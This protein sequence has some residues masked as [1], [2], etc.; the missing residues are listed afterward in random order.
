MLTRYSC[1]HLISDSLPVRA[2]EGPLRGH[3]LKPYYFRH[4]AIKLG[5]SERALKGRPRQRI[6]ILIMVAIYYFTASFSGLL[7]KPCGPPGAG[8]RAAKIVFPW[9]YCKLVYSRLN[10]N[11]VQ[12][13]GLTGT[14]SGP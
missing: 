9:N 8:M 10:Y 11:P 2:L 3:A 1:G 7:W 6:Y 14:K 12:A 4:S 13:A 5:P